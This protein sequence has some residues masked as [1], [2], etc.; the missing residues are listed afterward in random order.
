MCGEFGIAT[1]SRDK[2]VRFWFPAGDGGRGYVLSKTLVGHRNFV[3][4][5]ASIP[6]NPVMPSGGLVSGGMDASVMVWDLQSESLVKELTGHTLQ[7]SS[8]AID[9]EGQIVSAS[10]DG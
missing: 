4:P 6:P 10:V 2:T 8:V 7:V 1:G 5:V 3:G 9:S